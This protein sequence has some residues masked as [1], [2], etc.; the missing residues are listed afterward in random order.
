MVTM[1]RERQQLVDRAR[2]KAAARD[3]DQQALASGEKSRDD[4]RR[5]NGSFAIPDARIDFKN[6]KLY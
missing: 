6:A 1:D 5:E 3:L 4:L 2:A